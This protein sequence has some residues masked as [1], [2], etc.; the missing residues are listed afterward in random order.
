MM[1]R[2]TYY[3]VEQEGRILR[4]EYMFRCNP[5]RAALAKTLHITYSDAEDAYV[6]QALLDR[7]PTLA[8]L[9]L[10]VIS[11]GAPSFRVWV[12]IEKGFRTLLA[13]EEIILVHICESIGDNVICFPDRV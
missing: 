8:K 7:V 6:L 4:L 9:E 3:H 12:A 2:I 13:L 10:Y 1:N 11:Y 5:T